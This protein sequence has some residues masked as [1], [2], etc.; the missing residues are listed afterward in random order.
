MNLYDIK[1]L[2]FKELNSNIDKSYDYSDLFDNKN[3]ELLSNF[4]NKNEDCD[5]SW[6]L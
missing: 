5:I 4:E 1:F 3:T 2:K 6:G